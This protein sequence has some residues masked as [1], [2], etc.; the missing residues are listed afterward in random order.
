MIE[1]VVF[2]VDDDRL[3]RESLQ[4]LIESVSLP[5]RVFER[6]LDFLEAYKPDQPGCVVLDVRMPDI[7]GMELHARMLENGATIPVI[8]V[9]GHAD[10]PMAVRAMKAGAY[11]FIQK[12]YNDA[13]MLERIQ[14]AIAFD[15]DR[16]KDRERIADIERRIA[17]LS[18]REQQVMRMV[19]RSAPN[20]LIARELSIS[21]KTV[22]LHRSNLMSKMG[23]TS[24]TEL[25]RL[26]LIAD[27]DTD[28]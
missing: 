12:P 18:P 5:V 6:G 28:D 25:V 13:L 3:A 20:K 23:V 8:I 16:Q 27:F 7:N 24:A 19:I 15:I 21:V 11:D 2:I 22:E 9:T 1:P 26:V 14:G 10:V 17:E 4:W